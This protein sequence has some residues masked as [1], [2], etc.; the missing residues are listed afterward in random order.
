MHNA[1][2]YDPL[3]DR[4]RRRHHRRRPGHPDALRHAEAAASAVR[5]A[6]DRVARARGR[7]S[8][9]RGARRRRRRAARRSRGAPARCDRRRCST[10]RSGPRRGRRRPPGRSVADD[11]VIVLHGDV[12]LIRA[13]RSRR[14]RGA[15]AL[16]APPRRW[17]PRARRPTRLGASCASPDGTVEKVVETKR[18]GDATELELHIREVNTG[19]FAFEGGALLAA[20]EEVGTGNAQGEYY[21]PDVLPILPPRAHGGRRSRSTTRA[22]RSASTTG[23]GWPR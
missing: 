23:S 15:R 14:S 10:S 8:L 20:L 17:R 12:P 21:L 7:E 13:R 4:A 3:S 19:V 22:R 1:I 16:S 11:T 5:P 6:D 18:P 2:T 9:R